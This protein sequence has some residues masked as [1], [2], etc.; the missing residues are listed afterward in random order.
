MPQ[1]ASARSRE[2][3][4][5]PTL[6]AQQCAS[7]AML[8]GMG[9]KNPAAVELGRRG[10]LATAE[11]RTPDERAAAARHAAKSRWGRVGQ[12]PPL[13]TIIAAP[14]FAR[15]TVRGECPPPGRQAWLDR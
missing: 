4:F 11:R 9:V 12:R 7:R 13:A 6:P 3:P 2:A 5:D 14:P 8:G 1:V 10:G 15:Q